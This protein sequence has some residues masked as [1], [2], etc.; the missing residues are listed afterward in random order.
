MYG[1]EEKERGTEAYK[2][3]T[4][5]ET[6]RLFYYDLGLHFVVRSR[7]FNFHWWLNEQGISFE[8]FDGIFMS[9]C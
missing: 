6:W 5:G 8:Y 3:M 4:N 1:L 2:F 7:G 9:E